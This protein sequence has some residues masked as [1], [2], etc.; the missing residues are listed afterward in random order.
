MIRDRTFASVSH[1][2]THSRNIYFILGEGGGRGGGY[3]LP[4]D[5]TQQQL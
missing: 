1:T 4:V 2:H 5:D 3:Q